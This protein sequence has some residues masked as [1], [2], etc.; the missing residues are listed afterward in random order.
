MAITIEAPPA[1][2]WPWLLQ[3]GFGRAGWYSWDHLDNWVAR[4]QS[5]S[6]GMCRPLR[7]GTTFPE[8]RTTR[9]GREVAALEREH[10]LGLRASYDL[11]ASSPLR[12]RRAATALLH[13]FPLGLP[14]GGATRS[15]HPPRGQRL[16]GPSAAMAPAPS[17]L[18]VPGSGHWVMQSLSSRGSSGWLKLTRSHRDARSLTGD[19]YRGPCPTAGTE[20]GQLRVWGDTVHASAGSGPSAV[21]ARL[22][23]WTATA[24][25]QTPLPRALKQHRAARISRS[26]ASPG[27]PTVLLQT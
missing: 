1:R 16:L 13:G 15:S 21:V 25:Q 23:S 22:R 17:E 3:M 10:F 24:E 27:S 26:T 18:P 5:A 19:A 11:R 7:F 12:P 20:G 4:A 8:C 6:S 9:P 14:F 2:V